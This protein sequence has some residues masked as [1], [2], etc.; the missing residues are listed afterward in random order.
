MVIAN[1]EVIKRQERNTKR[2]WSELE[3]MMKG[4][5]EQE[6]VPRLVPRLKARLKACTNMERIVAELAAS[7][8]GDIDADL[9]VSYAGGG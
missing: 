8:L 3:H 4:L 9:I 7:L 5:A 6:I 2:K 1:E